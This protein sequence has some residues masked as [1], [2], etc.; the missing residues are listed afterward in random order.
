[1]RII[2]TNVG[3]RKHTLKHV[4]EIALKY[5]AQPSDMLEMSVSIVSPE[6]IRQLNK[7]FRNVDSVTDVLSFPTVDANRSVINPYDFDDID[8]DTGRLNLGDV[9]ICLQRAKQQAAE[10]GHSLKREM[11]FLTLH[12]L[13]HLLGYDHMNKADE[14]Q[15]FALQEEILRQAKITRTSRRE[16]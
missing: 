16:E 1:M 15:M 8:P 9:I 7:Q 5:L 4:A 6:E 3:F 13:L 14:D 2:F 10:Y 11:C 12:G